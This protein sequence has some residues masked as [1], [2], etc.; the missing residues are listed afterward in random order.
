MSYWGKK[1]DWLPASSENRFV[2]SPTPSPYISVGSRG[3]HGRGLSCE[4]NS[5]VSSEA[6]AV[7]LDEVYRLL[8]CP[9]RKSEP[10]AGMYIGSVR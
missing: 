3:K 4:A 2:E 9:W 7:S 10:P 1:P 6:M 5:V 8:R